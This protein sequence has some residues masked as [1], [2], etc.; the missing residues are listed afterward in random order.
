VPEWDSEIEVD[1]GLARVLIAEQFPQ[2]NVSLLRR[3]GEGWDNTVWA[4]SQEIAFRFPRRQIAIPG[5]KREMAILPQLASK[6][7]AR[8]PDAAFAGA[9]STAFPW[10]WFGSRLIAG[11]EVAL[12]GLP[13]DRRGRL[14]VQ[15]G[16]F[17]RR[18]H[19]LP[20]SIA[21][22]L[23]TDPMGRGDMAA[24]VPRAQAALERVA[25]LW[26]GGERA[27]AILGTAENLPPD[28]APVLVHGDLNLRH[29]LVSPEGGLAGVIDWGDMCRASR[30]VD[31]PLYWSLF[32][33][34]ARAAFRAAYGPLTEHTLAQARVP[35]LFFDATLASTPTIRTCATSSEKRSTDLTAP[36]STDV[37]P[38]PTA[39]HTSPFTNLRHYRWLRDSVATLLLPAGSSS[40]GPDAAYALL[41]SARRLTTT[42]P[43]PRT[44]RKRTV[45]WQI[46][47]DERTAPGSWP[48]SK[49]E[50]TTCVMDRV[51]Y[52]SSS[53]A[54]STDPASMARP[55]A[56]STQSR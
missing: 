2:L 42:R 27:D 23:A 9:A 3:V 45:M 43:E 16:Q 46:S 30:S 56:M 7:P 29:A 49:L 51:S 34:E 50:P 21:V 28:T 40:D 33:T 54:P 22:S 10:P 37:D 26:D 55:G 53:T 48:A 15:L 24:R 32:D 20:P 19:S 6:L 18:L 11:T 47:I 38:K 39:V 5:V 35:A 8:I 36:S 52:G 44:A 25:Y 12:A 4:A 14:A 13:T 17:L 41:R 31:L 1:E